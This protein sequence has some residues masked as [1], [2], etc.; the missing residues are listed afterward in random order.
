MRIASGPRRQ[1]LQYLEQFV[2]DDASARVLASLRN[3]YDP[4]GLAAKPLFLEMIKETLRDLPDDMFSEMILYD[5]YID[6]SLRTKWD[7]LADPGYELTSDEL[8]ENLKEILEDVAVRLQ[9]TNGAY[10]YLRDYP[11]NDRGKIAELLWKMR[12]QPVPREPFPLPAQDDAANRVGIR[13]LLKAVPAPDTER[14]PVDFFHRSMREYFVARFIARSLITDERR[15][16]QILS[17]A[18]LLPEIAHFAATILR[19]RQDDAALVALEKLARSA[20]T[21][22]DDAYIGGNAF[23]LLHGA[24]GSLAKRDW[25]GLRLD[26]ARL[27]GADL[28]GTR[29]AGGSLRYANLDNADLQDADLTEANLEGV[30]LEET[31]QVLAVTALNGNQ[32]IA[33][34]E[35]H[36]LRKWRRQPGADW[37][38]QVIATL[39]HKTDQLQVTPMGRV[40]A[41]GEGMLSVL[42][43]A[44]DAAGSGDSAEVDESGGSSTAGEASIVRCTFRTSSRCRAAVLGGRTALFTEEGDSGQLLVTWLDLINARILDK[45][46]VDETV[47]A[48]TQLDEIM[49]ALATPNTIQVVSAL[50]DNGRKAITVADP[51][52]TCLSVRDD[53]DHVLLAAG[54]HDGSV[55]LTQ[56]GPADTGAVAPQWTRHLHDGPVTDIFLDA[57]EQIITGSIDRRVCVTPMSAI[58][59]DTLPQDAVES[60]MQSLHLT[61]HCKGVRF[62]GVRTERER[63][64]LRSYAES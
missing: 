28:H 55:S 24:G 8:I 11:G 47:T 26:H 36:S 62:A 60:A 15:A 19:T 45:L 53:G 44:G 34:Y 4:I 56:L 23:T 39:D 25:S 41:S 40:L 54:H 48:W 32:V 51:S 46:D 59:S 18:P 50:G 58:R 1:R 6:K 33:A 10:L 2:T 14:W 31:S 7:L 63:E 52:V 27:R 21:D 42:D 3:L 38:S 43:V 17:A 30:R 20:T 49:F 13:S 12:D 57:E 5:T 16:R 64:K 22:R 9:E 29:F 37:E 35:D 61:L